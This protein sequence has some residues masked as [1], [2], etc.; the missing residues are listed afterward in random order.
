MRD[1]YGGKDYSEERECFYL[2][3]NVF[4]VILIWFCVRSGNDLF[5]NDRLR[6]SF[7]L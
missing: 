4:D 3:N 6:V 2:F 7:N 1:N 5:I